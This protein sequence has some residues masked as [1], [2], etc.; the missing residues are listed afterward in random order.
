MGCVDIYFEFWSHRY[1]VRSF[2]TEAQKNLLIYLN[3]KMLF[4]QYIP[5]ILVNRCQLLLDEIYF[6]IIGS[7]L[8]WVGCP[9]L[10]IVCWY[11]HSY[12]GLWSLCNWIFL[13]H[14]IRQRGLQR[15]EFHSYFLKENAYS[16]QCLKYTRFQGYQIFGCRFGEW[17]LF[18]SSEKIT[19]MDFH[20]F[21]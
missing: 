7:S 20:N 4:C 5:N 8:A 11:L 17:F 6:F 2:L 18:L 15:P 3:T 19:R 13:D 12:F 10:T 1:R 9:P 16:K 14:N 21:F